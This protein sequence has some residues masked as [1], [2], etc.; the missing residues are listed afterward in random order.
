M[1]KYSMTGC[2]YSTCREVVITQCDLYLCKFII[3]SGVMSKSEVAVRPTIQSSVFGRE[4]LG[5]Q[6]MYYYN[7]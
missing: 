1:A 2:R 7:V 4:S 6:Y 3:Q 5:E